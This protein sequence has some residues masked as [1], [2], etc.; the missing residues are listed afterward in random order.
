M[1]IPAY[2]WLK[3]DGG[4]DIKGSVD[5]N[6]R[7][8]SIEIQGFGHSLHLPTD[9]ATGKITGTHI[10]AALGLRK[11]ST[12]LA[13]I[14]TKQPPPAKPSNLPSLN[15]TKSTMQDRKLNTSTCISK[16][17]KLFQSAQQCTTSKTQPSRNITTTKV[18]SF[19]M[20]K[21]HGNIV[22]AT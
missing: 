14:S 2:L 20:K 21:S 17:L 15:G 19:A 8:G 4:A 18:L 3:D 9:G 12:A 22:T 5:V 13:L 7:E 11:N 10:H 16:A 1:A 6:G